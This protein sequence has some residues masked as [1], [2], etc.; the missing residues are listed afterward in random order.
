MRHYD[1]FLKLGE[2]TIDISQPAYFIADIAANHDGSLSRAKELIY[3]A[4]ESGADC[5]KFQHYKSSTIISQTGFDNLVGSGET[6]QS[7]WKQSV[8]EIYNR[9]HARDE[10]NDDLIATC[11]DVGIDFMTTPYNID[12]LRSLAD[13]CPA[14][15]IGSGDITHFELLREVGLTGKPVLLAT[16]ASTIDEVA[17][18][19]E[20]LLDVNP[21]V[22]LMQCNTNYTGCSSNFKYVNLKVISSYALKWPGLVLG[23]SDHTPG[24]SAVLGAVALGARVIEKHFTD[25]NGREGPDHA[26]ALNPKTWREM[27]DATRELESAFGDGLKRV[28]KNER[29]TIVVQ[30]R[31]LH[32]TRQLVP[33][34]KLNRDDFELLRPCPVDAIPASR[35]SEVVGKILKTSVNANETL[36]WNSIR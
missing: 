26:F 34:D 8:S 19:M 14:I 30:R 10:W 33:G 17:E 13:H 36:K 9:Y 12:A 2:K 22:C 5:A 4:K 25:D 23:F 15:K 35:A 24:H 28:E 6:H 31:A 16:G 7:S 1:C 21:Q 18:A 3:F 27:V 32:A 29:E 20:L 11:R